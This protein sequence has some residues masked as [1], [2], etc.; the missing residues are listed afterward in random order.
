MKL[1]ELRQRI[2]QLDTELVRLLNERTQVVL[3]V[4]E[5][6][7]EKQAEI[8][9]P[10]RE[11]EVFQRVESLNEGPLPNSAMRAVYREI[12]SASLSLEH[13]IRIA[14]LGPAATF[15]HQ[16]AREKFGGSVSY[17]SCETISDVFTAVQNRAADYG[18]VP[19]ENST[20]GGVTHTL[21][22]FMYTPVKICAEIYLPIGH[23]LLA[24]CP[25]GEIQQIYSNP[26][27]FGQCR[28]WLQD[29][30]PGVGLVPVSSTARAAE[31]ASKEDGAAA[32]ASILAS[33]LYEL[34]VLE[35]DIQD[36]HGNRTRFLVISKAYGPATG[37][38]KTAIMFTIRH[39]AGALYDALGVL[40]DAGLNMTR[41]ESRPSKTKAW[42]YF[43]FVDVEGHARDTHVQE[44]F[45]LLSEHCTMLT[46]L[47]SFPRAED[48]TE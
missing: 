44:S 28:R 25:A 10:A 41:I 45:D 27:V 2:D 30:L 40:K 16:A 9:V 20:E 31:L 22:R 23:N 7:N 33:E 39:K 37:L 47:G 46:I 13:D 26:Q 12:M 5:F 19:V 35:R 18:V 32:L 36:L 21:D 11:L 1:D 38:D 14:Y 43:F 3:Q 6:K 4:G 34:D 24:K 15:T 8:Y 17:L 29:N 42:E 48:S